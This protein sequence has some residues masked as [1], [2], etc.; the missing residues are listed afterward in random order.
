MGTA[1]RRTP[2]PH[3]RALRCSRSCSARR[4]PPLRARSRRAPRAPASRSSSGRSACTPTASSARST[5]RAVKRFQR[6]HGLTADGIVGPATWSALKRARGRC[7][8]RQPTSARGTRP[9]AAARARHRRRRRLRPRHRSAPSR[10][11]QRGHGLTADGVVGPATWSALGHS[12]L[13]K[14]LKRRRARPRARAGLPIAVRARDRRRQ[15]DRPQALQLRRRPRQLQRLR[16][17]LLGLGLLRAARRRAAQ[18]ADGL[19]AS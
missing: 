15:P 4:R 13:T 9:A 14:V 16:L 17:R 10:R 7:E 8:R 6:R 5:K 11:F 12:G 3:I 18:R 2:G 19:R 1:T